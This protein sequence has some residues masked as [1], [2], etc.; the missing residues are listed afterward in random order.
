VEITALGVVW[1]AAGIGATLFGVNM[2]KGMR[3]R[4]IIIWG[5]ELFIAILCFGV[6]LVSF[7][8]I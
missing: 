3:I 7:G 5:M 1:F 6:A 4:D 8:V 2:S